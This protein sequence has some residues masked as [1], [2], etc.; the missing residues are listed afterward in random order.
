MIEPEKSSKCYLT[1]YL[2]DIYICFIN[3]AKRQYNKCGSLWMKK[4]DFRSPPAP[5]AKSWRSDKP[6]WAGMKMIY[7]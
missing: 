5:P 3:L 7:L 1:T 2:I 4:S 6:W